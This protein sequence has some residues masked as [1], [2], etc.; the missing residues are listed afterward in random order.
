MITLGE[1]RDRPERAAELGGGAVLLAAS[2]PGEVLV[3]DAPRAREATLIFRHETIQMMKAERVDATD[4]L[5]AVVGPQSSV[6]PI[7]KRP[8]S[9]WEN[10]TVGRTETADIVI[11][12]PAI[13]SVH[14]HF[15]VDYDEHLVS[16][17]DLGS[18]NGTF[19]NRMPLQPHE[20]A[21]LRAGDCLRFGQSVFYFV[22]KSMLESILGRTREE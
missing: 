5:L 8:E 7:I 19:L 9:I 20:P 6:V 15:S 16:V 10:V 1:L 12:D 21:S 3:C 18:S 13:S 22:T 17:E 4:K 11:D 14:A 2:G